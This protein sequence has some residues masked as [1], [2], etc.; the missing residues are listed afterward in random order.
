MHRHLTCLIAAAGVAALASATPA[1]AGNDGCNCAPPVEV[2]VVPPPVAW[3]PHYLVNQGP[4]YSGPGLMAPPPIYKDSPSAVG[5]Y[6][7]VHSYSGWYFVGARY[8]RP[9]YG[10]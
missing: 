6:P 9:R 1:H 5:P 2:F 10:Y 8:Y 7:Y 3:T 4:D